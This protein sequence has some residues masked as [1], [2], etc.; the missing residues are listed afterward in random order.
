M[1]FLAFPKGSQQFFWGSLSLTGKPSYFFRYLDMIVFVF[2]VLYWFPWVVMTRFPVLEVFCSTEELQLQTL[3]SF[4]RSFQHFWLPC[5][6]LFRGQWSESALMF[7]DDH[8]L[9]GFIEFVFCV[10]FPVDTGFVWYWLFELRVGNLSLLLGMLTW[11]EFIFF[12]KGPVF[13]RY[14]SIWD[15]CFHEFRLRWE[16]F[17][18]YRLWVPLIRLKFGRRIL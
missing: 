9:I 2:L 18:F 6:Y 14:S 16:C 10:L 3:C 4:S 13:P 5:F 1:I 11:R 8:N 7:L 12:L 17:Y 15:S